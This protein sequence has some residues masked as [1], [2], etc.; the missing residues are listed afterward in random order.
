ML[1]KERNEEKRL[2]FKN[3]L[4]QIAPENIIYLDESGI[5]ENSVKEYAWTKKGQTVI[6]ER[7]GKYKQRTTIIAAL[8]QGEIIAPF[9]FKGYTDSFVFITWLTKCLLPELVP[10]KTIVLDNAS[11]HKMSDIKPLVEAAGCTLLP[12][13]PYSPDLNPIENYWAIL[14]KKIKAKRREDF[15]FIEALELC[16]N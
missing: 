11:F 4:Q 12:L 1:Y 7:V 8:N 5:D 9:Y 13:P 14:K 2:E 16:C 6:G 3:K 15:T 10:G